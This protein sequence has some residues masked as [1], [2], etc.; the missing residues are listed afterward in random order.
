MQKIQDDE[1]LVSMLEARDGE[2]AKPKRKR[3]IGRLA[4]LFDG[5]PP[6]VTFARSTH[7]DPV[8]GDTA[9]RDFTGPRSRDPIPQPEPVYYAKRYT[10][11]EGDEKKGIPPLQMDKTFGPNYTNRAQRRSMTSMIVK[12]TLAQRKKSARKAA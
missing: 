8:T 4:K 7:I 2:P 5:G 12:A 1:G 3:G 9:H 11:R 10:I 6:T